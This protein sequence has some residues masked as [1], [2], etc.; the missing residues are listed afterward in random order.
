MKPGSVRLHGM[1]CDRRDAGSFPCCGENSSGTLLRAGPNDTTCGNTPFSVITHIVA[2]LFC[3]RCSRVSFLGSFSCSFLPTSSHSVSS[4][5]IPLFPDPSSSHGIFR[6]GRL[7]P[8][9]SHQGFYY[10]ST[11]DRCGWN[12][13]TRG[14]SKMGFPEVRRVAENFFKKRIF[15]LAPLLHETSSW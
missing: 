12:S 13:W 11:A 15:F 10:W 5:K 8:Q 14:V 2:P 6:G 1:A 7:Y 3:T 9:R 4:P